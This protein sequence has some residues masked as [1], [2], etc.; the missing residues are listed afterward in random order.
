MNVNMALPTAMQYAGMGALTGCSATGA[1]KASGFRN[2]AEEF[3]APV[4][5]VPTCVLSSDAALLD[6]EIDALLRAWPEPS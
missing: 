6:V 3:R 4:P 1:S 2:E 5:S